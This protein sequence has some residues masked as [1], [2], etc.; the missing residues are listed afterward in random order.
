MVYKSPQISLRPA[1]AEDRDFVERVYFETQRWIIEALFGWRG[2]EQERANFADGY[3]ADT[4]QVI[5]VDGEDAGW[6]TVQRGAD[7]ELGSLY[8]APERQ[9]KG[10]GTKLVQELIDE[11]TLARLPLKLSTAKINPARNLYERLGFVE[12]RE[13]RYKIYMEH[14]EQPKVTPKHERFRDPSSSTKVREVSVRRFLPS[15]APRV[16]EIFYRSIHEVA[17]TRYGQ[18][19]IDAWAPAIPS[20]DLWLQRLCEFHTFVAEDDSEKMVAWIAMTDAGYIDMLFCLPEDTRCGVATKLYLTVENIA[21]ASGL[22]RLTAHASVLAQS[23]FSKHGWVIE[24]NEMSVRRGV[25]IPRAVM[26]KT[27]VNQEVAH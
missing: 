3:D 20:P 15:D 16:C 24:A 13:D 17:N 12:V 6:L 22:T 8:L 5:V 14:R 11:A 26:S 18:A 1:G 19:Q 25:A 27:L 7:I 9:R 4:T 10:L 2:Q 21:V 23:F